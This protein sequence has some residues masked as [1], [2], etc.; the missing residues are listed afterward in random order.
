MRPMRRRQ[1]VHRV[2]PEPR[3]S[4]EQPARPV[5]S[6]PAHQERSDPADAPS[7][8]Q[9]AAPFPL[10]R[11]RRE[12]AG[13]TRGSRTP[14]RLSTEVPMQSIQP[15]RATPRVLGACRAP[16]RQ[17]LSEG[18][19]TAAV[20]QQGRRRPT[21]APAQWRDPAR[22]HRRATPMSRAPEGAAA[23]SRRCPATGP[24]LADPPRPHESDR[25]LGSVVEYL[26]RPNRFVGVAQAA[27]T[28]PHSVQDVIGHEA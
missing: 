17:Q 20:L 3:R 15:P 24:L 12:P 8:G 22:M 19:R 4:Q 10:H 27:E 6:P 21:A 28:P 7:Q 14:D 23:C 1:P 16:H 9:C 11:S 26:A 5:R 13:R 2:L 25:D 18:G